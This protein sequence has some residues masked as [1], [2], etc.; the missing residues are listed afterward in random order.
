MIQD[1]K[2]S[3]PEGE[4]RVFGAGLKRK[5]IDF[6]PAAGPSATVPPVTAPRPSLGERYLSITLKDGAPSMA[7]SNSSSPH[8]KK[9]LENEADLKEYAVCGICKLPINGDENR[10]LAKPEA[11]EASLAHQVCLEHSYPPSHLDR[12]RQGLKYLSSYGWD[13]DSRLGLGAT[14]DGI[15]VPIKA[16]A[17]YDTVG[18]GVKMPKGKKAE[19]KVEKL[20][21]KGA[22]KWETEEK[23]KRARLQQTF[24]ASED[25]E[26]YLGGG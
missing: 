11:H 12:N 10:W 21:A 19:N 24:Y 22:R 8:P 25:V 3:E 15:R 5:R 17:K 18:L 16:T 4:R 1:E 6:V 9:S 20:D 14:G 13:P 23:K 7:P 2:G 26:K